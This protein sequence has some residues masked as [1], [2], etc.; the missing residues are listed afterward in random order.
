VQSVIAALFYDASNCC[1][2]LL[3]HKCA[4]FAAYSP[5]ASS[6]WDGG[7]GGEVGLYSGLGFAGVLNCLIPVFFAFF[8][9]R[10]RLSRLPMDLLLSAVVRRGFF[11]PRIFFHRGLDTSPDDC[12]SPHF[13]RCPS[14]FSRQ[15]FV[16]ANLLTARLVFKN[17]KHG[18]YPL[19]W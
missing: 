11:L 13:L 16:R 19:G 4:E 7:G 5:V 10:P 12:E 9:S 17:R 6:V 2:R 15:R 14:K 3:T 1:H 8:F 18:G